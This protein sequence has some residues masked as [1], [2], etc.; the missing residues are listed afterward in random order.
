MGA[1]VPTAPTLTKWAWQYLSGRNS[2][3]NCHC[4]LYAEVV[5]ISG[6]VHRRLRLLEGA[7]SKP[8]MPWRPRLKRPSWL[9]RSN[10]MEISFLERDR[11]NHLIVRNSKDS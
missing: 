2:G 9:P 5:E 10:E 8:R 11:D 1:A 4:N 7:M 3:Q 6:M